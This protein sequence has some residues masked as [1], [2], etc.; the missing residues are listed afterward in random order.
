MN[1]EK[2]INKIWKEEIRRTTP[3]YIMGIVFHVITI[4]IN[5]IIPLMIGKILD[6]LLAGNSKEEIFKVTIGLIILLVIHIIPRLIYRLCFFTNARASDI[7][8]RKKV[9]EHLQKVLPEYYEKEEKGTYLAYLSRELLLTRKSFGN[10]YWN[11]TRILGAMITSVIYIFFKFSPLVSIVVLPVMI[12]V[13]VYIVRKYKELEKTL[14]N[15]REEFIYL[16]KIIQRNTDGFSLIKMYNEQENEKNKFEDINYK[17]YKANIEIG[18]VKNKI[19]NAMN[20]VYAFTYIFTFAVGLF[21]VKNN[22]TTVGVVT[23]IIG[24]LEFA[25]ADVMESIIPLLDGIGYYKQARTRYNYFYNLDE[26]KNT[27]KSLENIENIEVRN[28]TYSFD[29]KNNALENINM[30]VKKNEKIGIIG[31]VGSGKTLLMNMICGFYNVPDNTIF[32][33]GIDINEYNRE[34]IFNK[35]SYAMQD[36]VMRNKSIK[37]NAK[38]EKEINDEDIWKAL[39]LS[40]I[41]KEVQNMEN[42]L[43]TQI[44]EAASRLSGGQKQRINIARNIVHKRNLVIYDDTLSALDS[45]TEEKVFNNIVNYEKDNILIFISNKVSQMEK[46]D[47]VYLLAN[48]KIEDIGAHEELLKRN[49]LYQEL[50]AYEKVGEVI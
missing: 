2:S 41:S 34:E 31:Q 11:A 18:V 38:M 47:R 29:N 32:I 16:S 46:M 6:M 28:L 49:S 17:T 8:L 33:N 44:G 21:L 3:M 20:I 13:T 48:G 7:Y 12:T 9:A 22:V 40:E 45:K 25:L 35:I 27:G 4:I 5:L 36:N 50:Q 15:Y 39:E 1:Q 37:E 19:S 26:Y 23:G 10:I 43:D 42:K 14:E 24:A 30:Q